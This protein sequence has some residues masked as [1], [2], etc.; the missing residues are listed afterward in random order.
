MT[1][2]AP[3]DALTWRKLTDYAIR[4]T[5]ERWQISRAGRAGID[6]TFS[7][8]QRDTTG[9]MVCVRVCRKGAAEAKA[10]A[11]ELQAKVDA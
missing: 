6:E 1:E 10:L 3:S 5:C 4:T 2:P 9:H 8:W 11:V 7:L